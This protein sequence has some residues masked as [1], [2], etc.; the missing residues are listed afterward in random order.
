[1]QPAFRAVKNQQVLLTDVAA[2]PGVVV[3]IEDS[4]EGVDQLLG[5]VTPEGWEGKGRPH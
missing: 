2:H 5:L 1:M 3:G 4:V